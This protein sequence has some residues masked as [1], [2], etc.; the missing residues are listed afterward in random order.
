MTEKEISS[1]WPE[2]PSIFRDLMTPEEAAMFLR[3]DQI[4]HTPASA[5]RT[6]DYWRDKGDPNATECA[7]RV[8]CLRKGP[9]VLLWN[10]T[11]RSQRSGRTSFIGITRMR[12]VSSRCLLDSH[13]PERRQGM[14]ATHD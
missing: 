2:R 14:P 13:Q 12:F 8:S 6:L 4:G 7:G 3:L 5:C 10:D 1:D 9:R 11:E